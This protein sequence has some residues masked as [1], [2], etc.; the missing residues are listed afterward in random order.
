MKKLFSINEA[1]Q[2]GIERLRLPIWAN[3]LDHIK[4]D[5]FDK[6]LGPW[7]HLYAPFNLECNGKDPMPI[8]S[9]SMDCNKQEWEEYTGALPDSEEY[10]KDQDSYKGVLSK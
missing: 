6:H 5:I 3:P 4:I 1:A 2:Q 7:I 8:L 10:R 9:F